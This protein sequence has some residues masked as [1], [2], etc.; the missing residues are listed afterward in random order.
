MSLCSLIIS[1]SNSF[2]FLKI[3]SSHLCDLGDVSG[4]GTSNSEYDNTASPIVSKASTER[5]DSNG[6][7]K[8]KKMETLTW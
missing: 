3:A 8:A 7:S 1:K 5:F 4:F 6:L 2:A